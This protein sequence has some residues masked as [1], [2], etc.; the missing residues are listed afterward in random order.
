MEKT[1]NENGAVALLK[2]KIESNLRDYRNDWL[3]LPREE[4]IDRAEEIYSV[5][6]MAAFVPK[7]VSEEQAE[8]LLQF[9]NPLE[10]VSDEWIGRNSFDEMIEYGDQ[11]GDAI[12]Y[13]V[14]SGYAEE[15]YDLELDLSSGDLQM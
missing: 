14:D 3:T 4:L 15:C 12:R 8:Y 13:I 7:T 9:R 5:C 10:V 6:V 1:N 11:L 2:E